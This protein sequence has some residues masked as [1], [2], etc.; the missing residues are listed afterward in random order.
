MISDD[1]VRRNLDELLSDDSWGIELHLSIVNK[2]SSTCSPRIIAKFVNIQIK[3]SLVNVL[4]KNFHLQ[5]DSKIFIHH[6]SV[7]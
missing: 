2:L 7:E 1:F 4:K 3:I 5:R 6:G